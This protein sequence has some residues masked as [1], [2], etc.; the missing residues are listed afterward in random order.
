MQVIFTKRL[1]ITPN[2][3]CLKIKGEWINLDEIVLHIA[4]WVTHIVFRHHSS[5]EKSFIKTSCNDFEI[6]KW[7]SP[8]IIIIVAY[9]LIA[10]TGRILFCLILRQ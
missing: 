5:A 3:G 1:S 10:Y 2:F 4:T 9:W 6:L 7:V 8:E